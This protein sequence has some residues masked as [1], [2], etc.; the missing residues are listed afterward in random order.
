MPRR[1]KPGAK[2]QKG[3]TPREKEV[4]EV[5]ERLRKKLHRPPTKYEIAEEVG[6]TDTYVKMIRASLEKKG[7]ELKYFTMLELNTWNN[8]KKMV[9]IYFD[10]MYKKG[11][12]PSWDEVSEET[13]ID[14]QKLRKIYNAFIEERGQLIEII[15]AKK[16]R[17]IERQ[18]KI[19]KAYNELLPELKKYGMKVYPSREE[20]IERTEFTEGEIIIALRNWKKAGYDIE[21]STRD[22]VT[23]WK[24]KVKIIEALERVSSETGKP[25]D[26]V[27]NPEIGK[28]V[29]F[30]H[31]TLQK[32]RI[33][34]EESG[35]L[36]LRKVKKLVI[37]NQKKLPNLKEKFLTLLEITPDITMDGMSDKL[38]VPWWR[39]RR[40]RNILEEEDK[41]P[42]NTFR[43]GDKY[44][45]IES[46]IQVYQENPNLNVMEWAKQAEVPAGTFYKRIDEIALDPEFSHIEVPE[47]MIEKVRNSGPL[48][49]LLGA[50]S[51]YDRIEI[52]NIVSGGSSDVEKITKL[53]GKNKGWTANTKDHLRMLQF[54][55]LIEGPP[56]RST[57]YGKMLSENLPE[58]EYNMGFTSYLR[59]LILLALSE[60]E[61]TS[62]ELV[63]RMKMV[64]GLGDEVGPLWQEY[65]RPQ[66]R[67]EIIDP[68]DGEFLVKEN[69]EYSL[70]EKGSELRSFL[71]SIQEISKII[72][73]PYSRVLEEEI[74]TTVYN[75]FLD[76]MSTKLGYQKEFIHDI[77]Q[78]IEAGPVTMEELSQIPNAHQLRYKD[79]NRVLYK[80]QD[81]GVVSVRYPDA[82]ERREKNV[83][84][85]A[86]PQKKK[87]IQS[88]EKMR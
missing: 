50:I 3:P 64:K 20:L 36:E 6:I 87:Y 73:Q 72:K 81:L 57:I 82:S 66:H 28:Y 33:E 23:A 86:R 5:T 47:G 40:I 67:P 26:E 22:E 10:Y 27:S 39:V 60:G 84:M 4:I 52:L 21:I 80:L 9:E 65:P 75:I 71:N 56:Y 13:E 83:Q 49:R 51:N 58:A 88:L 42:K 1:K 70:T 54:A 48:E 12:P 29:D 2:K 76:L 15:N 69:N 53:R 59:P 41:L 45:Q 14:Y 61:A 18:K 77:I 35:V 24:S 37:E 38:N 78:W 68:L 34:L 44:E 55:G 62:R 19:V 63:R 25:F 46:I 11:R 79:L 85:V 17:V 16:K 32:Y 30:S 74:K 8:R 31:N 7:I 43:K